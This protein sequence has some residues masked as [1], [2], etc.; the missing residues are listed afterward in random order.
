MRDLIT[1]STTPK[2]AFGS[3]FY[4]VPDCICEMYGTPCREVLKW[5]KELG[6]RPPIY[7]NAGMFVFQPNVSIYVHLLNTLKFNPPTQFAEQDFLNMFFKD[8]YKPIS[9]AYNLLLAMLWRHPGKVYANKAKAVHYCSPGAK[10]WK[11]TG[12]EEHMDRE[13]IKMLVKKWWDI[14]NDQ[15]LDHKQ[16]SIH[17]AGVEDQVEANRLRAAAF[18]DANLT[19]LNV[20][21]PSAA[22]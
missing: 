20:T 11:Y 3:H 18:S 21:N 15:T 9:Y 16:S 13:D 14:Y 6:S 4:A 1:F 19:S 10:P 5:P 17:I 2:F 8:K 7:F 12:K 22:A